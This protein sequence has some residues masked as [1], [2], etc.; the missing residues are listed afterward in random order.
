MR[1]IKY[2]REKE[3]W[4]RKLKKGKRR[5]IKR[6]TRTERERGGAECRD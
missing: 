4:K 3:R 2:K 6:H 5:Q 1:E